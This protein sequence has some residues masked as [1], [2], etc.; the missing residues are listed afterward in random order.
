[1][2]KLYIFILSIFILSTIVSAN[3]LFINNSVVSINKTINTNTQTQLII[4]NQESYHF[5]NISFEDNPYIN[6]GA[7]SVL[8]SGQGISINASIIGNSNI[9]T[10]VRLRGFYTA[11]IGA[12]NTTYNVNVS[13]FESTPCDLSLVKGDKI[14]WKNNLNSQITLRKVEDSSAV[15]IIEPNQTYLRLFSEPQQFNYYFSVYGFNF[16]QSCHIAVL[17][18][19]GLVNN[20]NLDA[21]LNLTIL[22]NYIPTTI[23]TNIP[24]TNFTIPYSSSQEGIMTITNNGNNQA[25]GVHLDAPWF[26]FSNNNFNLDAGQS[27]GIVYIITPL[28]LSANET[29]QNYTKTLTITGNFPS[30]IN[31]F[32]INIPF[33]AF[34]YNSSKDADYLIK[35]FCPLFP[36]STLCNPEPRVIYKIVNN[37]T[38]DINVTITAEQ[39]RDFWL[40][41]YTLGDQ[42]KT[43]DNF[44]KDKVETISNN[45][46]NLNLSISR[47]EAKFDAML[48]QNEE[49]NQGLIIFISITATFIIIILLVALIIWYKNKKQKERINNI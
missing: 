18:D 14:N 26:S 34:D 8:N 29:G 5:Y 30:I 11:N 25:I 12:T 6:I 31:N 37:G 40:Y 35:V 33:A 7:I 28:I 21:R 49:S 32:N 17:N 24:Q 19:N 2:N 16:P 20:P 3:G 1:M 48:K 46:D 9:Q 27:K 39:W 41:Q 13:A 42:V 15:M 43:S 23:T 44:V 47:M 4:L 45:N 38:Q 36:N 22:M 10:S